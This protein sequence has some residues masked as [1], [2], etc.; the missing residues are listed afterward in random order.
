MTGSHR[1]NPADEGFN[2]N[3]DRTVTHLSGAA[4]DRKIER[5][6]FFKRRVFW[7]ILLGLLGLLVLYFFIG[8]DTGKSFYVDRELLTVSTVSSDLFEDR[9]PIRA[10]VSPLKTV[11]IDTTQGGRVE[12]V[13]AENGY[14]LKAG[15][16]ILRL[17]NPALQLDV[18][19]REA[20]VAE[21]RNALSSLRLDLRRDQFTQRR[22]LAD[23]N[24][25]I[26][27]LERQI[28]ARSPL[29]SDGTVSFEEFSN[30]EDELAYNKE[31]RKLTLEA[32][33]TDELLQQQQSVQIAATLE[34]LE[35]NLSVTRE[36]LDRLNVKASIDGQLTAFNALVGQ[37]ISPGE[38]IGRIDSP[39]IFKVVAD[40]D[41][42]YLSRIDIAQRA[43]VSI[44]GRQHQ[45]EI[46]NIN[47]EVTNGQFQ[48]DFAFVDSQPGNIRRGQTLQGQLTLGDPAPSL[49]I[50]NGAFFQDTGGSWIFV[51]NQRGTE[52]NRRSVR[53]GRRNTRF[54]E[55]EDG[56]AE[57]ERVVTSSYASYVESDKLILD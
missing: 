46:V 37:S 12:E 23:I 14:L 2:E 10:R 27:R 52:A 30:L 51:L 9:I 18:I 53:L 47:P 40:L 16:P 39:E 1:A 13:F 42:F 38:R 32:Q 15:D 57:D 36:N 48:V 50:P 33:E 6:P 45:I 49:L 44:A 28:E 29:V 7:V 56:L 17:S 35:K 41:E 11:F 54:I 24:Y 21:Q 8:R 34:R 31:L 43:T 5:P 25:N 55:V 3:T 22:Q 19:A 26:T 20:D 4:M